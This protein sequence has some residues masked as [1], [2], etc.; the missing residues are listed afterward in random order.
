MIPRSDLD[1]AI[2]FAVA[3]GL[4]VAALSGVAILAAILWA[5]GVL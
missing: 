4:C 2:G 5:T 1:P 3:I